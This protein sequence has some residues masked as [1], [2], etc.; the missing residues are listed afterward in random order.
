MVYQLR[1]IFLLQI[2]LLMDNLLV[3][4]SL[5]RLGGTQTVHKGF[6]LLHLGQSPLDQ[7]LCL[8]RDRQRLLVSGQEVAG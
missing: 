8:Y 4:G 2:L 7:H 5:Y 3:Q 1:N 6:A